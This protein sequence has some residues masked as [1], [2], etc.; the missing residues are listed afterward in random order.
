[1]KQLEIYKEALE[2]MKVA[3]VVRDDFGFRYW[4]Y[5]GV[6]G[7]G[8]C[9]LLQGVLLVGSHSLG[10]FT[11]DS[12]KVLGVESLPRLKFW[13]TDTEEDERKARQ[14]RIEHLKGL[15]KLYEGG[16]K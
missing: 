8:L 2:V 7:A 14:E 15:I 10:R 3:V 16:E 13:F 4:K 6:E 9:S 5:D 1:M 11:L 12:E